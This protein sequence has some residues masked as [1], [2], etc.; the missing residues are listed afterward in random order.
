MNE[1][2]DVVVIGGGAAG[3]SGA[4]TLGRSRRRV[5]VVD[6]GEPRNAPA[7]HVHSFL[8]R[9]GT[10]PAELYAAG[11]AEVARYGGQAEAGQVT[12]LSREDDQFRLEVNGRAV[13]ARRLLVATGGRDELPDVPGKALLF[14]Q[15]TARL[16]VLRHT[17]GPFAAEQDEQLAA[18][19]I[20][21]VV[22]GEWRKWSRPA[23]G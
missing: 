3:L 2:Y 21:V 18:L 12:G 16:T 8:T 22:D 11:Q 20:A 7:G 10:P 15:L 9:D 5:L 13:T 1:N 19:G 23:A 17:A 6:A 14:S 4:V